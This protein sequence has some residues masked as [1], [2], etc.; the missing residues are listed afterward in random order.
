MSAATAGMAS[1]VTPFRAGWFPSASGRDA[2]RLRLH[3]VSDWRNGMLLAGRTKA[4]RFC[5]HSGMTE[6]PITRGCGRRESVRD[7]G[8]EHVVGPVLFFFR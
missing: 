8:L 7:A 5:R 6:A 3:S 2:Y 4:A 1:Y